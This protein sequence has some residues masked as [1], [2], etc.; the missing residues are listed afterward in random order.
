M[1]PLVKQSGKGI[2]SLVR[3]SIYY[4]VQA[5]GKGIKISSSKKIK[6]IY[7]IRNKYK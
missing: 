5:V 4:D 6:A 1:N 2:D 7:K 3:E